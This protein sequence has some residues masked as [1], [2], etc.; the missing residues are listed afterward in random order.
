MTTVSTPSVDGN[1][2]TD[3]PVKVM[4][5]GIMKGPSSRSSSRRASIIDMTIEDPTNDFHAFEG[6]NAYFHI[7]CQLIHSG[8]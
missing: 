2:T 8:I 5:S 6:N 7:H 4:S 1:E 3:I